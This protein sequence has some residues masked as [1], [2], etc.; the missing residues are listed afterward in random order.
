VGRIVTDSDI[1]TLWVGCVTDSDIVTL[2][3]GL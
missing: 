2:S 3:V 1:V